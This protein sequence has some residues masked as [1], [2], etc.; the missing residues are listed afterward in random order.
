[1]EF[2]KKVVEFLVKSIMYIYFNVCKFCLNCC[3][4]VDLKFGCKGFHLCGN[5]VLE[6][7]FKRIYFLVDGI[8]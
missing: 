3:I 1:M 8:V 5:L 2:V 7:L 6:R 4:D